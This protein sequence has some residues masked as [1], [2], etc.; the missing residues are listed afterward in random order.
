MSPR[1]V[2]AAVTMLTASACDMFSPV[3]QDNFLEKYTRALCDFDEHC[4]K[5]AFLEQFDDVDE[6]FDD[7]M[8]LY[9][10]LDVDGCDFDKDKAKSCLANAKDARQDCDIEDVVDDDCG[11]VFDC[12]GGG[13]IGG[14]VTI[15]SFGPYYLEAYC[16][17]GCTADISA[18]CD[19][20]IDATSGTG[21][22]CD[23][24]T[25]AAVACVDV[26]N[27]TCEA[28]IEGSDDSYPTA[29]P[30]CADVCG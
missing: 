27:W 23:F 15:E 3:N 1:L 4:N 21:Y 20:D 12:D 24:D 30:E 17:A 14:P 25:K 7:T 8:E 6:C 16:G 28:L 9:E 2:L 19:Q 10:D 29:P 18:V 26:R 5:S 13:F 22:G 11:E